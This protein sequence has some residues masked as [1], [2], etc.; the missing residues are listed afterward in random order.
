M[1]TLSG[2]RALGKAH[3]LGS[4]EIGKLAD[5]IAVDV[6]GSHQLPQNNVASNLVYANN[7][8]E[9]LWSWIG[10]R[11]IMGNGQLQTLDYNDVTHRAMNWSS[12]LTA[13]RS[14]LEH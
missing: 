1:A 9:V 11:L 10:G 2:A 3:Q 6:S 14:S 8:S 7:G 4:I 12:Q 5:L 13:L